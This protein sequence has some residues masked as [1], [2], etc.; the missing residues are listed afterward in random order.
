M[1]P[2]AGSVAPA[3]AP[4][5]PDQDGMVACERCGGYNAERARFC[6]SCGVRLGVEEPEGSARGWGVESGLSPI[7]T[8][9]ACEVSPE[10]PDVP[11]GQAMSEPTALPA[12]SPEVFGQIRSIVE[13]HGGAVRDLPE[14]SDR[15]AAVFGPEP[16]EGDGPLRA[17]RAA[18]GIRAAFAGGEGSLRGLRV[19]IGIG[20]SEV[21]GENPDAERLW[22][23]RVV[24]LAVR[25]LL[26]AEPGEVIVSEGAYRRV[27]DAA[28]LRPVD[29]RAGTDDQG[30]VGPLRLIDVT[31]GPQDLGLTGAPLIGR[32]REMALLREAFDGAVAARR[33]SLARLDGGAGLGKTRLGE[34]FL[35]TLEEAGAATTVI[36][37]CLPHGEGGITWPLAELVA[38]VVGLAEGDGAEEARATIERLLQADADSARIAERLL[39]ALGLPG[40]A[41]AR[42]T[43]W[44]LRRLLEGAARERPLVVFVDDADRAGP[45]FGHL[46]RE[47]AERSRSEPILLLLAHE[48]DPDG[49]IE[50]VIRLA[51]LDQAEVGSLV[52]ATLGDRALAH[53]IRDAVVRGCDGNPLIAEQLTAMLVGSGL[54]RLE[55]GR[56]VAAVDPATFPG[57]ESTDTL[58][59]ER[60]RALSIDERA[61]IGLAAVMGESFAWAP[62]SELVPEGSREAVRDHLGTLVGSR[63]IG[64]EAGG[65][66]VF[67]HPLIRSAMVAEVPPEVRAEVHERYARWLETSGVA[68]HARSTELVGSHLEAAFRGSG[69]SA[70]GDEIRRR[71]AASFAAAAAGAFGLGDVRGASALWTRAADLLTPEDPEL[72]ELLFECGRA[73]ARLDDLTAADALFTRA[74]RL[75]RTNGNPVQEWRARMLRTGLQ[76][77]ITDADGLKRIREVADATIRACGE[78]G[79]D[80]GLAWAWSSRG[81]VHRRRGYWAAAAD[82]A[83]RAAEHARFAGRRD[84]E[85]SAL[86]DMAG[87]VAGGRAPISESIERCERVLERL[88][89]ERPEEQEVAALLALLLARR[90]SFSEARQLVEVAASE[91]EGSGMDREEAACILASAQIEAISGRPEEAEHELRRVAGMADRVGDREILSQ[92]AASLTHIFLDRGLAGEALELTEATEP[93]IWDD[94]AIQ[95]EWRAARGRALAASGRHEEANSLARQAVKL[96]DQTDLVE[97]RAGALLH[98]AD[99]LLL[100]GR[101]NE[102]R[103]FARRSL[104]ALERKSAEGVAGSARAVLE[105]IERTLGRDVAAAATS[106][107]PTPD[108]DDGAA[109]GAPLAE[110]P[111]VED[112]PETIPDAVRAD[113]EEAPAQEPDA[114]VPAAVEQPEAP[115]PARKSRWGF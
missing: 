57:P 69:V 83:E 103:L 65:G 36:V 51:P 37:R 115:A 55:L 28:E 12:A 61:V 110:E 8:A 71:A 31:P 95:V 23:D 48:T 40:R 1:D 53:D 43:Q 86:R 2:A 96:A 10:V 106:D 35:R 7:V 47:L 89:G 114:E 17:L 5:E 38:R 74:E 105:Q 73:N 3:G 41:V 68:A 98:L 76:A 54:L 66:F 19:R 6:Q 29:G 79:D 46:L 30:T 87:A 64:A 93:P 109:E 84:E 22:R 113:R 21:M 108:D 39:P 99:V 59:K 62:L 111:S 9:L 26:M 11:E 72:A 78:L 75:A 32:D 58:L 15:L 92:V 107:A 50:R 81:L 18:E 14:S 80:L 13:R 63:L 90:G 25:L 24:D 85:V 70:D 60:V 4:G 100:T 102:A 33:C 112:T 101:P 77:S 16:P 34:E 94:V 67:A 45:G 52:A 49:D 91:L 104:R 20:T 88:R 27:G 82:A 56:W 97:L 44:A 42:E